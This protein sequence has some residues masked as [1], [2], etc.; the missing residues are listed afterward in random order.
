MHYNTATAPPAAA[1]AGSSSTATEQMKERE[2]HMSGV[3]R[4]GKAPM[5]H[6]YR[7]PCRSFGIGEDGG[8]Q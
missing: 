4:V 3:G 6:A 2:S 5:V 7:H 1:D 8:R